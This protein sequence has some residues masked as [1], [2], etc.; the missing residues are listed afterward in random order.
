M[1][2]YFGIILKIREKVITHLN[3]CLH[4]RMHVAET[5]FEIKFIYSYLIYKKIYCSFT[6]SCMISVF[7]LPQNGDYSIILFFFSIQIILMFFLNHVLKF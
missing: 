2:K 1:Y 4:I 6:A 3:N 5:P 7:C